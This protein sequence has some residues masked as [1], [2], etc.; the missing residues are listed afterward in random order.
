[1]IEREGRFG[2]QRPSASK[3]N[4]CA[5][6][7]YYVSAA[8]TFE[9]SSGRQLTCDVMLMHDIYFIITTTTT[10]RHRRIDF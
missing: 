3:E 4:E 9:Y 1:M 10:S 7:S 6:V 2:W 8:W 5:A